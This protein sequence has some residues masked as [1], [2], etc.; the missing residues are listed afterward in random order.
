MGVSEFKD[1]GE[2]DVEGSQA[3][4]LSEGDEESFQQEF[5]KRSPRRAKWL[6]LAGHSTRGREKAKTLNVRLIRS[7]CA[8]W[9]SEDL[10]CGSTCRSFTGLMLS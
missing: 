6:R 7:T 3:T 1:Y 5:E 2:L 9:N 10:M 8:G 4:Q